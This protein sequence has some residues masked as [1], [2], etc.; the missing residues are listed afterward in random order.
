MKKRIFKNK[1]SN[2]KG[3]LLDVKMIW[4]RIFKMKVKN[5]IITSN[6]VGSWLEVSY[7]L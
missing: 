4:M 5:E 3:S 7:E 1:I 6:N 2:L